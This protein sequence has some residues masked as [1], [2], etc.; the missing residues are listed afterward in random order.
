MK[1]ASWSSMFVP[2]ALA[3]VACSDPRGPGTQPIDA[4][5]RQLTVAEQKLVAG[6]NAFAFD[7]F[8]EVNATRRSENVFI[9]PLSASMAL[10]M[11]ANGAAGA[12]YDAMHSA[13]RL[14]S[15]TKGEVNEGYKSLLELL[16]SLDNTTD[17]RIV[18][19]IWYEQSFPFNAGFLTESKT[20]FDAAVTPLDFRSPAALPTINS[21]VNQSTAGKIPVIL[22]AINRD[23]V[24]FLINAIYFKGS[25]QKR[26]DKSQTASAPFLAY[27]E[28]RPNVPLMNQRGLLKIAHAPS[29]TAVDLPYG[30]SAFTMTV[31]LPNAGVDVNTVAAS[32][33][34]AGWKSL[35]GS[36][37][38]QETVLFLPRFQLTWSAPLNP[39]LSTLGMGAAFDKA[40]FTPMSPRGTE[41]VLTR[42]LQ[43]TFVDVNEDGTE[44]AAAT[45]VGVGVTSLP[46][47]IRVDRPFIFVIRERFSGTILF[48]GKVAKL[49]A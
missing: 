5:P 21:W 30:N 33:D 1:L 2:A 26:F 32:V 24:M 11:T 25:W 41:L 47:S 44:A 19:S 18:N 35:T 40:D 38:Q 43:K 23:E 46:P 20:F 9:S 14:G 49:P 13:L 15:A 37:A 42:V 6:S 17:F 22:D 48:I 4:L 34:D 7:L 36:L 29:Y 16:R 8:R 39:E 12:T 31:V 45:S 28:S 27:D 10:G 3:T